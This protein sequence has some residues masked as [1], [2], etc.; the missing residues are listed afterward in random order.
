[1][2]ING[3]KIKKQPFNI[4]VALVEFAIGVVCSGTHLLWGSYPLGTAY[5][6]SFTSPSPFALVGALTGCFIGDRIVPLSMLCCCAAYFALWFYRKKIGN[7]RITTRLLVAAAVGVLGSFAAFALKSG[8]KAILLYA[9]C[10][11][12]APMIFCL[13]FIK[14]HGI[15][16]QKRHVRDLAPAAAM[17]V[18]SRFFAEVTVSEIPLSL[19]IGCFV[20]LIYAHRKGGLYGVA[21]GFACGIAAGAPSLGALGITGLTYGMFESDSPFLASA[22][23]FMLALPAYAYLSGYRDITSAAL[24]LI[25]PTALFLAVR[26]FIA[27]QRPKNEYI[28][29][30][31]GLS[32]GRFAAAFSALSGVFYT[33]GDPALD[34]VA[35][36]YDGIAGLLSNAATECDLSQ[37]RSAELEKAADRALDEMHIAHGEIRISGRRDMQIEVFDVLPASVPDSA[38]GISSA[39]GNALSAALSEP[40]FIMNGRSAVMKLCSVPKLRA[41]YAKYQLSRGG[42]QVCGDSISCFETPDKRFCAV[43]A[44]GMGSGNGAAASSRIAVAMAEKLLFAGADTYSVLAAINRTLSE[45]SDE[46]FSTLD[47]LICDRMTSETS[48]TKSGASPCYLMRGGEC[49]VISAATPPLGI[50]PRADSM[51]ANLCLQKNDAIVM[52]TD[53]VYPDGDDPLPAVLEAAGVLTAQKMLDVLREY[54]S[55]LDT[56]GDD[57]TVCVIRFY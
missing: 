37:T 57:M 49:R 2:K 52:V 27:R 45:R 8:T 38:D 40:D 44:D 56:C 4:K 13:L 51:T 21:Y 9:V 18:I 55:T 6:L 3:M 39:L 29:L 15:K 46:I 19:C 20:T 11:T 12:F 35:A 30:Q 14:M 16:R 47:L 17:F 34:V 33:S 54:I 41:E 50:L 43:I 24:M 26:R 36:E 53:G 48:I 10:N 5:I 7:M 23:S 22:L 25:I 42:E 31:S 28:T 1:M 32:L